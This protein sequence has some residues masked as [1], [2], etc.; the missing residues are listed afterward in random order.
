M[1][2]NRPSFIA[3]TTALLLAGALPRAAFADAGLDDVKKRGTLRIALEGTF[4]P[5]NFQDSSGNLSGFEIDLGNA[6]AK[7]LGVKAEFLPTKW[8]GILAGLDSGRYD[9]VL[10]QVTITP[11]RQAKYD[12]SAP[13]TVSGIQILVKKADADRIKT[14]DDLAGKAVGVGLGTNYETWLRKNVPTAN[15]KTYDDDPTKFADLRTGRL[16]AVLAD[17]LVAANRIKQFGGDVVP[18]GDPL[19]KELQG[20][21]VRKDH[22]DLR[23][24]LDK[25]LL[26]L[27]SD[28]SF[29]AISDKWFGSDVSK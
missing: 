8:D 23:A 19:A 3:T 6:L 9:I 14:A 25:A 20:I 27:H 18:A 11:E 12:F 15:V 17:R 1:N 10:N 7:Q 5:F 29:V 24:A 21:A 22:P 16:D 13:Y 26:A 2:I 28:G 4:P